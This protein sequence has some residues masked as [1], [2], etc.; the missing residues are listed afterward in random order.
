M[1]NVPRALHPLGH[2]RGII[3]QRGTVQAIAAGVVFEGGRELVAILAGGTEGELELDAVGTA[4]TVEGE[5]LPHGREVL[6]TEAE[7]LQIGKTHVGAR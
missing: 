1:N 6:V 7:R 3:V 5:L 4:N 2:E